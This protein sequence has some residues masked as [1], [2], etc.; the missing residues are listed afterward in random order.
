[1]GE[2]NLAEFFLCGGRRSSGWALP[3]R[4]LSFTF[5]LLHSA[6]H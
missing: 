5:L 4:S 1:M 6:A 3:P 2:N